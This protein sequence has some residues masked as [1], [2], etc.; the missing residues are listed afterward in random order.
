MLLLPWTQRIPQSKPQRDQRFSS[1]SSGFRLIH[2]ALVTHHGFAA[3]PSRDPERDLGI[4]P[5]K[6]L[7][8]RESLLPMGAALIG[9]V[10][11]V[12][13]NERGAYSGAR[14]PWWLP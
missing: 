2:E 11:H 1:V 6:A 14:S 9:A 4:L 3:G 5:L 7:V 8:S 10:A 12:A 13:A